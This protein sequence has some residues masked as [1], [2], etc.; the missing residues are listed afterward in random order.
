MYD[1]EIHY[2]TKD[3]DAYDEITVADFEEAATYAESVNAF[4]I[5]GTGPDWDDYKKCWFCNEWTPT[6]NAD[7]ETLCNQCE[8]YLISRGEI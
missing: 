3:G 6:R 4:M 1:Y 2:T 8:S 5:C 7:S